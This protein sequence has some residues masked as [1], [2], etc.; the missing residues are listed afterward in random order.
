ME[1]NFS[2]ILKDLQK[3]A[4]EISKVKDE[5]TDITFTGA[6]GGGMVEVVINGN[7]KLI[8]ARISDYLFELQDK[9]MIEDLMIAAVNQAYEK[10][11]NELAVKSQS[12]LEDVMKQFL[13]RGTVE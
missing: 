3:Y 6:S 4:E 9:K 11:E 12:K 10:A 1:N 5:L 13:N 2:T 8:S 7:R